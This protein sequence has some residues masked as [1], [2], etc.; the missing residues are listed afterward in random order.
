MPY[1]RLL[2]ASTP[3]P[4]NE[5]SY[6]FELNIESLTP[7][8]NHPFK[9][10]E[11]DRLKKMVES[12]RKFGVITPI[13]VKVSDQSYIIISGHNRVNAAKI[14]GN[15]TIKAVLLDVDDDEAAMLVVESNF[16]QRESILPSEKALGYKLKYDAMKRQGRRSDLVR[17]DIPAG[18]TYETLGKETGE[19]YKQVQRYLRIAT[20]VYGLLDLLDSGILGFT[21]ALE[22]SYIN[23]EEQRLLL[24]LLLSEKNKKLSLE[25]ARLIRKLSA[26]RNLNHDTLSNIICGLSLPVKV[27]KFKT[28]EFIKYLPPGMTSSQEMTKYIQNALEYYSMKH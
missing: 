20:L 15:K 12:I 7:Y 9:L 21:Q 24:S 4:S 28:D 18:K 19:N 3:N 5:N 23:Q 14:A 26:E 27:L 1:S 13:A 22:F 16:R 25:Q 6:T 17:N 2:C 11:G 8:P 10:Y